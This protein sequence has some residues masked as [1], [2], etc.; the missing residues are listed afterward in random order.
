MS[1]PANAIVQ[2]L[3]AS[4]GVTDIVASRVQ[5]NEAPQGQVE[6][7]VIVEVENTEPSPTKGAASSVDYVTLSVF[8][9]SSNL[10]TLDTLTEAVRAAL[11]EKAAGT[12][13]EVVINQLRFE[14]ESDF[15]EE[16]DNREL[17]CVEQTYRMR[18]IR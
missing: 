9:Y 15:N 17:Y 18:V 13:G 8:T 16:I 4:S 3:L 10:A 11:D 12:Y 7:Y 6:P 14:G 5:R 2:I 1:K